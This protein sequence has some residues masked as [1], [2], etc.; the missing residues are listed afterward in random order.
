V[1][2][3]HEL[4][5]PDDHRLLAA[6]NQALEQEASRVADAPGLVPKIRASVSA[7]EAS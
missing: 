6:Q 4:A 5:T 2:G 7:I 1:R 3:Q